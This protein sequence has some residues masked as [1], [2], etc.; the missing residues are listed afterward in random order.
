MDKFTIGA[1]NLIHCTAIPMCKGGYSRTSSTGCAIMQ[2]KEGIH[3]ECSPYN[4]SRCFHMDH[5]KPTSNNKPSN[6]SNL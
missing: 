5:I 1:N 4:E 6:D 2:P 3:N